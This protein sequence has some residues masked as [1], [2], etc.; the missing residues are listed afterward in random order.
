VVRLPGEGVCGT[1]VG[2][3]GGPGSWEG[4]R[5]RLGNP[6]QDLG[7]LAVVPDVNGALG[8]PAVDP[9]LVPVIE[10]AGWSG[11]RWVRSLGRLARVAL[12]RW[13]RGPAERLNG[14]FRC[15]TT[16]SVVGS[17]NCGCGA[18]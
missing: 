2:D 11:V 14:G 10:E 8:A 17:A 5:D 7:R 12:E 16:R 15:R 3:D 4:Q 18:G 9:G 1:Q 6:L 13:R